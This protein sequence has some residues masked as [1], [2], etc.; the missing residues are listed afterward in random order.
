M[1]KPETIY[2]NRELS[3]L[4]F[5]NRVLALA[6]EKNVPLGERIKF[7]AIFGSNMD[8]FFMVRVGS[9]YDQTLLK[10]N[11]PDIVTHMTASEQIAAITPRVAELQAK[12]D[13]YYQHLI[14]QLAAAGYKKVDFNKLTKQ[15]EHFWKAYFQRELMP[16]LSPQIVD[17]RHPF[18]FLNNKDIYYIAQLFHK[19]E[20]VS[21]GIVPVSDRF[22]R[23]MFIKDGDATCFA[24]IEELVARYAATIFN[25]STVQ[26]QCLFRVTRNAD[27]TVDEGMMDH[28]I[29]F[30]DVMSELLKKR[31][32]LAA[33]RLQF[34][35]EAPQE[36]VK[37]LREKLV[38]PSSRCYTQT[39][40]LDSASL[41][42]LAGRIA[43]DGSHAEMFY[44][45][46]K[47]MQAPAGYDLYTEVRK[48]DVLLAYPYQSIRPFIRMLQ[49]AG[50]DP[51]VVSIKMTLYRMASD[52]Q[53]VAALI[54]AAENGKEVVA[55]VEL[56]ARFDEQNNIDWSKQL[57]DAGCTVLYGFDDYKVHS[58]LTLITSRVNGKYHY[59]T[60]IGT[61]N[62]NEKTS[63]Q[64]TDLSFITTRQEIGE[65][66]S[67]VF[68]NMALQRLT[69]DV[70]TMLVAPLHFKTVLLEEMDRQIARA[71]QGQEASII[72]KNNSI[73]DPQI[74]AK[75]IE[76]SCAGVRVD[77][78]VRGICCVRAGVPGYTEN[79][80]IRSIVGRYLEHSRI[81]CFGSGED[82]RIYIA[83]GDFLTRN[84]ERRVEVGVRVDDA[85]IAKKLRGIL[86]LQLRDTVNARE[87]QPDGT[88]TKVKPAEGQPPVDSQMAM[89]GY[90]QNG[91]AAPEPPKPAKTPEPPRPAAPKA[92]AKPVNRKT[93]PLR[94]SRPGLWQNRFGRG[95]GKK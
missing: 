24:F 57:Q 23:V 30:R 9:L 66:A 36:I 54:N 46:A 56:R 12:C 34:W 67:A 89:F 10:N 19:G 6:K 93:S 13:K 71:M 21:F 7:A 26:K 69:S 35:P 20:G 64:Y 44:P 18:P 43:G 77:M 53:I 81:Y 63:E 15:Q 55:M 52:S 33:V 31:R 3:W 39:S 85:A 73:N 27:I 14:E 49:R 28:D 5:D 2:I 41:F 38:V 94:P 88:Y 37:F 87:M 74:M 47:P 78:I 60:Q 70:G 29:D 68:N 61:G 84:T 92:V 80:H 16:L 1:D 72:L 90:F 42:K 79:V 17:A 59:L 83:S 51:D 48:H 40:P 76:A 32:K 11:K 8:E 25:A 62:Y 86:D 75:I 95:S 58:K 65:E 22:E 4:D 91:F 82:M 50:S 45:A